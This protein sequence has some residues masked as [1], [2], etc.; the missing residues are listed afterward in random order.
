MSYTKISIQDSLE[1]KEL[2]KIVKV[3]DR[4]FE[5][6]NIYLGSGSFGE[7]YVCWD[8]VSK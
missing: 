4:R 1:R 2:T 5:I 7:V 3:V 6:T 8:I